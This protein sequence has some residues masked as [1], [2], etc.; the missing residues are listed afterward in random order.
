MKAIKNI[1]IT[2][3]TVFVVYFLVAI[4]TF[5]TGAAAAIS[6]PWEAITLLTDRVTQL[7]WRVTRVEQLLG[8]DQERPVSLYTK[9]DLA[10]HILFPNEMPAD[11]RTQVKEVMYKGEIPGP[12]CYQDYYHLAKVPT[13]FEGKIRAK[14]LF[15]VR[16]VSAGGPG[17]PE[18]RGVLTI[19]G[20]IENLT[21]QPLRFT[22]TPLITL[23]KDGQVIKKWVL[24]EAEQYLSNPSRELKK[25]EGEEESKVEFTLRVDAANGFERALDINSISVEW[26]L[27]DI[28]LTFK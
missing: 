9:E 2:A 12:E 27:Q 20:F 25:S 11:P 4:F 15:G 7:E 16:V 26:E 22:Y 10:E 24:P 18:I 17:E 19:P 21:E 28:Q 1:G 5:P 23:K 6:D 3:V 13:E 8:L 14:Y